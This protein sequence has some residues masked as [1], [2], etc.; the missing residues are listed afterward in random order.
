LQLL[1]E[2]G[3]VVD[4]HRGRH[5]EP[6]TVR[7]HWVGGSLRINLSGELD[8]D[9]GQRLAG[10]IDTATAVTPRLDRA[11]VDL[12][13]LSFVDL[14]G[15]RALAAACQRLQVASRALGLYGAPDRLLRL[16]QATG[17]TVPGLVQPLP[18][19]PQPHLLDA[20]SPTTR[21]STRDRPSTEKWPIHHRARSST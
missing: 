2:G 11:Q 9:G 21:A 8:A 17:V 14:A 12:T 5:G 10:C 4:N 7:W 15:L 20:A 1:L 18:P 19:K 6:L 16:M 13:E 3:L